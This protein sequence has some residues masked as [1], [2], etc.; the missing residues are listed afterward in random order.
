MKGGWSVQRSPN[1]SH[2]DFLDAALGN[3]EKIS[4]EGIEIE[5]VA[6]SASSTTIR[7]RR[8]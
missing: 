6:L 2:P 7:L 4:V 3:G 1:S 8:G 5:V